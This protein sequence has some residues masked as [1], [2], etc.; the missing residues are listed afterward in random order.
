M[1]FFS[2]SIVVIELLG[3]DI[4]RDILLFTILLL[5]IFIYFIIILI[6]AQKGAYGKSKSSKKA[7]KNSNNRITKKISVGVF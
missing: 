3:F 4:F 5:F 7:L 6:T 1:Y 2:F